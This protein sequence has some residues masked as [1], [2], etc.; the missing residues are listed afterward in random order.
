MGEY[1]DIFT[2]N[3]KRIIERRKYTL[4]DLSDVL[5]ISDVMMSRWVNGHHSPT[6]SYIEALAEVLEVELI[7]FFRPVNVR[8]IKSL[9]DHSGTVEKRKA[10]RV[11]TGVPLR[12]Q[13]K[14]Q[15]KPPA[16]SVKKVKP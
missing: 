16:P 10:A 2:V 13:K 4:K 8:K 7:E 12:V 1:K 9:R 3:L 5:G 14:K 6:E 15:T 11:E